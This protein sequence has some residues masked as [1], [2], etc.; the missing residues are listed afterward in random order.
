MGGMGGESMRTAGGYG[1]RSAPSFSG[2]MVSRSG[3]PS[4]QQR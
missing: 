4:A 1:G 3:M 2:G